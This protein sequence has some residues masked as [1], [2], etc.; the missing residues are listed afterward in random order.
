[1]IVSG[2]AV[3]AANTAAIASGLPRRRAERAQE[4]SWRSDQVGMPVRARSGAGQAPGTPARP[5]SPVRG[6]RVEP[7]LRV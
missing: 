7:G 3:E 5:F 1:M 4:A 2:L 6:I